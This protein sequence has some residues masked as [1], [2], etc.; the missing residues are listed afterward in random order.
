LEKGC[1]LLALVAHDRSVNA[2]RLTPDGRCSVTASSD[3]TVVVWP[4]EDGHA[5][6]MLPGGSRVNDVAIS[7]DG[8]QLI[9]AS[10]DATLRLWD[11]RSGKLIRCF[12]G[13]QGRVW[14][15]RLMGDGRY[16]CSTS[17]DRDLR[18]W[19]VQTGICLTRVPIE[20]SPTCLAVARDTPRILVGGA[21]G[22]IYCFTFDLVLT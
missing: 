5:P 9:S 3:G 7:P 2:L 6:V 10:S 14:S 11:L 15:V 21:N 19:D 1:E 20:G 13:H 8:T 12:T 18:I 22:N 17:F 16:A 4:F